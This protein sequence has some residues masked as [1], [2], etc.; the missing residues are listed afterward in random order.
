[1]FESI[2]GALFIALG[3]TVASVP[4]DSGQH[5]YHD[6]DE[7]TQTQWVRLDCPSSLSESSE[8]RTACRNFRD[9]LRNIGF[10]E[11]EENLRLIKIHEGR[12]SGAACIIDIRKPDTGTGKVDDF[13][14]HGKDPS[15]RGALTRRLKTLFAESPLETRILENP[16]AGKESDSLFPGQTSSKAQEVFIELTTKGEAPLPPEHTTK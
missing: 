15:A 2:I 14:C 11:Q 7:K 10:V 12:I 3:F 8:E 4:S 16:D 1:M 9:G 5:K 13:Y 6:R